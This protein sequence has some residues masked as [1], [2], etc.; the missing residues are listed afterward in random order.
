MMN[1]EQYMMEAIKEA[2]KAESI[3]EVPIGCI[4]VKN[5][6]IIAR[7][8]NQR[9][10][11]PAQFYNQESNVLFTELVIQKVDVLVVV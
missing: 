10:C 11:V 6:Q 7:S 5:N 4:I 9:E 8:Y 3:D 2:K 1:D